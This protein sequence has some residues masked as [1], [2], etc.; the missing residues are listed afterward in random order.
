MKKRIAARSAAIGIRSNDIVGEG[1]VYKLA[2]VL[3]QHF[4]KL[5]SIHRLEGIYIYIY[6]SEGV[7]SFEERGEQD[8]GGHNFTIRL[9]YRLLTCAEQEI[10]N[11]YRRIRVIHFFRRGR[12]GNNSFR[13][14][15][16]CILPFLSYFLPLQKTNINTLLSSPRYSSSSK[17]SASNTRERERVTRVRREIGRSKREREREARFALLRDRM[18]SGDEIDIGS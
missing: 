12:R 16:D 10:D 4:Y 13:N 14:F 1:G 2:K 3:N 18:Q 5:L 8:D 11:V 9:Y 17:K 6:I 15:S 7:R